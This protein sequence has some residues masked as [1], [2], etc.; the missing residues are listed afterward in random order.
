M[1]LEFHNIFLGEGI[2]GQNNNTLYD[3]AVPYTYIY[4][5]K[6]RTCDF[7]IMKNIFLIIF[8]KHKCFRFYDIRQEK[9]NTLVTVT[10]KYKNIIF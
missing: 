5:A 6:A 9:N 8:V 10:P 4:T 7:C 3:L 2:Q 1:F